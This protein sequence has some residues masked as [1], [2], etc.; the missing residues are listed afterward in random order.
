VVFGRESGFGRV[1]GEG[2]EVIDLTSLA[3]SDGFIV[4]GDAA[5]D[6]AGASV[7][8]A[9]D[10][11]GDGYADLIVG[12]W[13]GDDGG[14]QTGEAYVVFGR[15]TGFGMIV[16]GRSVLD[17]TSLAP[18]DGFIVQGDDEGD[19]AG[20][21]VSSAGDINGDGYADLIVGAPA[22][23]NGSEDGEAY[24]VFGRASGFGTTV[25]G[26]SVI[27][28]ATL[29]PSDG[30]IVRGDAI[31][32]FAGVSVSSA[33]D[34]NGDGF[35]D[36]IVGASQGDDGG[37][38]A[39]EAYV[40]FG[41]AS[42]FGSEVGGRSVID[43]S[44]L[45]PSD[46]FII[47]GDAAGDLA[48]FSVSSAGDVNGDGYA[49]LIVGALFGGGITA[50]EAYVVFG[51]SSGFGTTG[52]DGRAVIDLS[53]LAPSD[54]FIVQGDTA[55]DRAGTS[56][57]SAGDVNGDGFDDLIVGAPNAGEA[58]VLFGGAFGGSATPVMTTGSAA[59][60]I[61]IGGL[62]GDTLEGGGGADSIAAAPAA[63]GCRS[64]IS[65]S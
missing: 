1:G 16:G 22:G 11:N 14:N 53:S 48:G 2:R 42:G 32:E 46:G 28:I 38:D 35:A 47:Q 58:Y 7:S 19:N 39:G 33:G 15:A 3:P 31:F 60:E 59:A 8:S 10:V 65:P 6:L 27:D 64:P 9:G 63:T 56:V 37:A 36:L 17:L 62:G 24:V 44:S 23:D 12:S 20:T 5:G 40:V 49:D 51:R 25:G 54:G 61:L 18:S 29:A 26:R 21:S 41:R 43:L 30:F 57:S 50:G 55:G 34:V 13:R 45:A 52:G 4:Q